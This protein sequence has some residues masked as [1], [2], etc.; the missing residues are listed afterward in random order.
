MW[1]SPWANHRGDHNDQAGYTYTSTSSLFIYSGLLLKQILKWIEYVQWKL[2]QIGPT[3]SKRT[4]TDTVSL[5]CGRG[6]GGRGGGEDKCTKQIKKLPPP[7]KT[8]IKSISKL[9]RFIKEIW[10]IPRWSTLHFLQTPFFFSGFMKKK[11]AS[12]FIRAFTSFYNKPTF[13]NK[14]KSTHFLVSHPTFFHQK[15]HNGL[16]TIVVNFART[17]WT[18]LT[19]WYSRHQSKEMRV[20]T[21]TRASDLCRTEMTNSFKIH[22][23]RMPVTCLDRLPRTSAVF[24]F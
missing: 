9:S 6:R 23:Y 21:S 8:E 22:R 19:L 13:T 7:K 4:K 24:L 16:T 3:T 20:R 17:M 2:K 1:N 18:F 15:K 11:D 5:G 10:K 12:I 14:K